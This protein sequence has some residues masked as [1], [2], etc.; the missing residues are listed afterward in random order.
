MWWSSLPIRFRPVRTQGSHG[1]AIN[2]L[3]ASSEAMG[4][5]YTG[6]LW[7]TKLSCPAFKGTSSF[8][9]SS[10]MISESTFFQSCIGLH[11]PRMSLHVS[12]NSQQGS[13]TPRYHHSVL[14][15]SPIHT[16]TRNNTHMKPS[17]TWKKN[18][19]GNPIFH[20][21][22]ARAFRYFLSVSWLDASGRPGS[23]TRS[24]IGP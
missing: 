10:R 21:Y 20:I 7:L 9:F 15:D 6:G 3:I 2:N 12:S 18:V 17:K 19:L 5:C 23:S 16:K 4:H 11:S 13:A 24:G 8:G 22:T 1:K 14:P